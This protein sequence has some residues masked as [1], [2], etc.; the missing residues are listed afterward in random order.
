[1]RTKLSLVFATLC[2]IA[3]TFGL[4]PAQAAPVAA[5][6]CAQ[7]QSQAAPDSLAQILKDLQPARS[8][9]EK[10]VNCA[11]YC[12]AHPCGHVDWICGQ[13]INTFGTLVCGC[14]D[15]DAGGGQ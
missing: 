8:A 13:H 15:P 12:A 7:V 2:L 6:S 14:Y 10:A 11:S 3:L 1:M 4:L 9:T 5:G